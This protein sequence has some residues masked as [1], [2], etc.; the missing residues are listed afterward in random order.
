M[1][2]KG[3][4]ATCRWRG[5]L[6][7][8]GFGRSVATVATPRRNP[9]VLGVTAGLSCNIPRRVGA[10]LGPVRPSRRVYAA[11]GRPSTD[12]SGHRIAR[13]PRGFCPG[14]CA[15]DLHEQAAASGKVGPSEWRIPLAAW[16]MSVAS[17][18]PRSSA[19]LNVQRVRLGPPPPWV[20]GLLAP[21]PRPQAVV[22]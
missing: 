16:P 19:A 4:G 20:L 18:R 21:R 13:F 17:R 7:R 3:S 5:S 10:G 22:R 14:A 2:G 12:T 6:R 11:T 9:R 1:K 15:V 8:L